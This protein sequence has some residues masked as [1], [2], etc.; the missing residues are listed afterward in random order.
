MAERER[1]LELLKYSK[2]AIEYWFDSVDC[3]DDIKKENNHFQ[4]ECNYFIKKLS[5]EISK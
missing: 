3:E 4:E 1:L 5:S 2:E